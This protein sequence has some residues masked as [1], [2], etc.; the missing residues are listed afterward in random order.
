MSLLGM[1]NHTCA[2]KWITCNVPAD[3]HGRVLNASR[4]QKATC[5]RSPR[6]ASRGCR[7]RAST[8]SSPALQRWFFCTEKMTHMCV[9]FCLAALKHAR[10]TRGPDIEMLELVSRARLSKNFCI[11]I[12]RELML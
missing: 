6:S 9:I 7:S 4:C 5:W 12:C 1:S 3:P 11:Q 2:N 10:H 8:S